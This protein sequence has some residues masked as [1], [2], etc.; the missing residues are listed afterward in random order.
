MT[1]RDQR[2]APVA[3]EKQRC[4]VCLRTS[5]ATCPFDLMRWFP[6]GV[7]R[8]LQLWN[9]RVVPSM[10]WLF[11]VLA[12]ANRSFRPGSSLEKE[13][14]AGAL[15][16]LTSAPGFATSWRTQARDDLDARR[17]F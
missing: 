14:I 9:A 12:G 10:K 17:R 6:C 16:A 4:A 5:G 3:A 11:K 8:V 7:Y 2:Q 15:R 1:A 13:A